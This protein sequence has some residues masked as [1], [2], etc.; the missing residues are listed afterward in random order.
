MAN[1]EPA[2]AQLPVLATASQHLF[3]PCLPPP[4]LKAI[5]IMKDKS[6]MFNELRDKCS[7]IS[8]GLLDLPGI[9][10]IGDSISPIKHIILK[11]PYSQESRDQQRN[12][13]K[14]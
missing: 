2:W 12:Y 8:N 6:T 7:H 13:L 11:A 14:K 1:L 4:F 5:D 3:H 10:V 9:D